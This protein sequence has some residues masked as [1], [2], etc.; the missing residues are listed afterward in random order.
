MVVKYWIKWIV[1]DIGV[2]GLLFVEDNDK[3]YESDFYLEI[4]ESN[5][6]KKKKIFDW[7]W[8]CNCENWMFFWYKSFIM[9]KCLFNYII[10]EIFGS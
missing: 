1:W 9:N 3:V 4:N 2:F 8:L 7:G 10:L 5:L 6:K